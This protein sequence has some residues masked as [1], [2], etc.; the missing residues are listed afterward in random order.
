MRAVFGLGNPGLEYAVTR[1]NLGFQVLDL[2]RK[3][4]RTRQRGYLTCYSL[5]YR[6]GDFLLVKPLTFMNASGEAVQAVVARFELSLANTL[7]I[8]DDLD[9]PFGRIKILPGGGA[10]THKGMLSVL[11]VLAREDIPRL[12]IGIGTEPRPGDTLDY[13]LGRFTPQEWQALFPTLKRAAEAVEVF[14]SSGIHRAMNTFNPRE[15]EVAGEGDN[16]IL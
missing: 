12:R 9:L 5:I 13:V 6:L 8:Y 16:S 1:H 7:V 3:L 11:S 15:Q 14:R 4:Y 10:G 2:Y